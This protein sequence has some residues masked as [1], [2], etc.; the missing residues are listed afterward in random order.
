MVDLGTWRLSQSL[1]YLKGKILFSLCSS[2]VPE[3]QSRTAIWLAPKERYQAICIHLHTFTL[4]YDSTFLLPL[5]FCCC[6]WV[7]AQEVH[8]SR[9]QNHYPLNLKLI[10][11][12]L[13]SWWLTGLSVQAHS[14]CW[15]RGLFPSRW[16]FLRPPFKAEGSQTYS[17]QELPTPRITTGQTDCTCHYHLLW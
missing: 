4:L 1:V 10:W 14:P 5:P 11:A 8:F 15:E 13:S 9:L 2:R 16:Y 17:S 7:I 3:E 12:F 6:S